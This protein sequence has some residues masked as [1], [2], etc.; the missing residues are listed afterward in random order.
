MES[1]ELERAP[2]APYGPGGEALVGTWRGACETTSL[3]RPA[4]R[5]GLGRIGQVISEKRWQWFG[6]FDEAIFLG[7]A[8]VRLGWASQL[9][10]WVFDRSAGRML[11][12][13]SRTGPAGSVV[14][15]DHPGAGVVA[16]SRPPLGQLRLARRGDGVRISG[17][18]G[19][20]RLEL[21][22]EGSA[23]EPA[24][25]I[26]P[27]EGG[28]LNVTQKQAGLEAIGWVELGGRRRVLGPGARACLDYT[29]GLLARRTAWRWAIGAGRDAR[30][31]RVGFNLVEGFN[32]GLENVLWVQG[33][34]VALGPA[35]FVCGEGD[36]AVWEVRAG[37][38]RLRARL[39][40]Q[41]H[42]REDIEL[43]VAASRYVQ[44]L[45]VWRG[46]VDG[47]DF[48]AWGVA[49]DHRARW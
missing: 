44:P 4:R 10:L 46:R 28:V 25:A 42:R 8:A 33:H 36:E 49:E 7:G 22:C 1:E 21:A 35:Q 30:G 9:F 6:V 34:P 43:G 37:Q 39:E 17:R 38:G 31:R 40:P 2:G 16:R 13:W 20:A 14:I 48:E 45:G 3:E 11:L 26:A 15:S 24:T 23:V 18:V 19:P 41:G 29:H 47:V 12:D 5:A 32:Q 27:V